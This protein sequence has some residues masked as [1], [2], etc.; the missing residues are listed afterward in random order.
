[1][2]S[3]WDPKLVEEALNFIEEHKVTS[4]SCDESIKNN[5]NYHVSPFKRIASQI[6][7]DLQSPDTEDLY[8]PESPKSLRNLMKFGA[9]GIQEEHDIASN[10]DQQQFIVF[11][12]SKG[13]M[14]NYQADIKHVSG[15]QINLIKYIKIHNSYKKKCTILMILGSKKNSLVIESSNGGGMR[16]GQFLDTFSMC[17]SPSANYYKPTEEPEP[18]ELTQLNI[19]AS[20]MCLVSK[21]KFLCGRCNSPAVRLRVQR[22]NSF[23]SNTASTNQ[24]IMFGHF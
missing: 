18:W 16:T 4:V 20:I 14:D 15:T 7:F 1:L 19:E 9:K 22:N 6:N 24:V 12:E 17:N 8:T 3:L 5:S 13:E 2:L 11:P 23:C 21:V 10:E